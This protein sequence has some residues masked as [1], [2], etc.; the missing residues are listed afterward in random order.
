ME[1]NVKY[2]MIQI[3]K[4]GFCLLTKLKENMKSIQLSIIALQEIFAFKL[5]LNRIKKSNRLF[6]S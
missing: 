5:K 3:D 1:S 2:K 6:W 4:L